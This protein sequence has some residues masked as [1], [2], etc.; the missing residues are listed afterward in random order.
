MNASITYN[1]TTTM[2]GTRKTPGGRTTV[3]LDGSPGLEE[4]D[5]ELEEDTTAIADQVS[6]SFLLAESFLRVNYL[7]HTQFYTTLLGQQLR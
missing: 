3:T 5:D 1:I 7:G 6:V 4:V 2:V